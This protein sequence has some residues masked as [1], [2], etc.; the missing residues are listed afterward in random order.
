[1]AVKKKAT[2]KETSKKMYAM[3]STVDQELNYPIDGDE[4]LKTALDDW[5]W[6]VDEIVTVYELVPVKKYKKGANYVEVK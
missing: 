2:T 6:Y 4:A 3:N 5:D 1:M